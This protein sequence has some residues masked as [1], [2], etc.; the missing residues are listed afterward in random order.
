[1]AWKVCKLGTII[2]INLTTGGISFDR[3]TWRTKVEDYDIVNANEEMKLVRLDG[4]DHVEM[5][6]WII[7]NI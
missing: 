5:K 3:K 4:W 6:M 7:N 2:R 1:M